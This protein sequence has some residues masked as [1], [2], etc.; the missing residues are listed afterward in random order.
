[1]AFEPT[2]VAESRQAAKYDGT[3][4]A[5]FNTAISDFSISSET[6]THL[7]FTSNGQSYTVAR[8]GYIAWYQGQVTEVFQN[9]NDFV[10]VYE[11]VQAAA[12]H[13]HDLVLTTGPAKPGSGE[14][15]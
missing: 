5:D 1:M 9:Q 7:T 3:N 11:A 4:S 12:D 15:E 14:E 10:E 2:R 6:P 8:N 13:V